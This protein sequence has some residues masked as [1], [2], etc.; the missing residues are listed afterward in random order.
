M[1]SKVPRVRSMYSVICMLAFTY[2][3]NIVPQLAALQTVRGI[4]LNHTCTR[5][6]ALVPVSISVSI[7]SSQH[8]LSRRAYLPHRSTEAGG[9]KEPQL[10]LY[11]G[12]QA[13]ISSWAATNY[14]LFSALG[15][16]AGTTFCILQINAHHT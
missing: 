4:S 14:H 16:G 6:R 12:P 7:T 10:S 11:N 1:I 8:H 9:L 15:C 2:D 5:S 3:I 13:Y